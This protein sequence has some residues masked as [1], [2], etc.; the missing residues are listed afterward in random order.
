MI[1]IQ[2]GIPVAPAWRRNSVPIDVMRHTIVNN[3]TNANPPAYVSSTLTV[4]STTT[5]DDG[6]MYQCG[7]SVAISNIVMLNVAGIYVYMYVSH[8]CFFILQGYC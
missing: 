1:F 7:I 8:E 5:S 6:I 3:L 4:S 2:S